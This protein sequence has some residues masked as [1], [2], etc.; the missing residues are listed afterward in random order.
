[1]SLL[2]F[3]VTQAFHLLLCVLIFAWSQ[4]IVIG[5]NSWFIIKY[6][7]VTCWSMKLL[8]H[9]SKHTFTKQA[10]SWSCKVLTSG[11]DQVSLQM[12]FLWQKK[13]K[14]VILQVLWTWVDTTKKL[15]SSSKACGWLV[16]SCAWKCVD[17][18]Q[19]CEWKIH[20]VQKKDATYIVDIT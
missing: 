13:K 19:R 11:F 6:I 7:T 3:Q 5:W 10:W 18:F 1:M 15:L 16:K 17:F 14:T 2:S 4:L 9:Q 20:F 12:S 8:S